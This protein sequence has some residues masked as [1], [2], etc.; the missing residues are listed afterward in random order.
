MN[1]MITFKPSDPLYM[2][3]DM[4]NQS[5]QICPAAN[6]KENITS[7]PAIPNSLTQHQPVRLLYTS[8][9]KN[10]VE[11]VSRRFLD[12][13]LKSEATTCNQ[14]EMLAAA[15]YVWLLFGRDTSLGRVH[16][17]LFA[18]LLITL[19]QELFNICFGN[20]RYTQL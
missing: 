11:C 12:S 3:C 13:H 16:T 20:R 15:Q 8:G 7:M 1:V 10:A 4:R 5:V 19:L 2:S 14:S 18:Q 9:P 6:K 17:A